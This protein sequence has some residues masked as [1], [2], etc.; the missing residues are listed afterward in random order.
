M[1]LHVENLTRMFGSKA[2]VDNVSFKVEK[3]AFIGVIG[4][5]G[6]GKSTLLR[7]M[8]RLTDATAGRI[9]FEDRDVLALT[10]AEKR[11]WQGQ[12]SMIFQ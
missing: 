2:A 1:L 11:G 4:R 12:C 6:A 7:I 10:G 9:V 8:N 3:S 5:S